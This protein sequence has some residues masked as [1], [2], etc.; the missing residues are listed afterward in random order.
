MM[1]YGITGRYQHVSLYTD[2]NWALEFN[3][4]IRFS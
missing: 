3:T 4:L 2:I 1:R